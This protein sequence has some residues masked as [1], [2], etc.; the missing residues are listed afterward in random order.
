[1]VGRRRWDKGGGVIGRER[2][3]GRV[4]G[5]E[6]IWSKAES[7]RGREGMGEKR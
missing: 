3:G 2:E 1:M 7:D 4:I 5:T 6:D